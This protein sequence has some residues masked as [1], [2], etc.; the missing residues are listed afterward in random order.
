MGSPAIAGEPIPARRR[1]TTGP[2]RKRSELEKAKSRFG[3]W[4][5]VPSTV[6]LVVLL[7]VPTLLTLDYSFRENTSGGSGVGAYVGFKNFRTVLDTPLFWESLR[8]TVIFAAGFVLISTVVGLA[9]A[10]LLNQRFRGRGL[11]RALLILPWACPWLV[12]GILWNRFIGGTTNGGLAQILGWLHIMDPNTS[13][14]AHPQWALVMTIIA[15][16]WRQACFAAILFLAGLQ[17]L[18]DELNEA[19]SMDGAGIWRRFRSITLPWLRPVLISVTVLNVIYGFL[20]FD[21]IY[22]LTHGGPGTATETLSILIYQTLFLHTHI[23]TGSAVSVIL[24]LLS[25]L[26]G[27]LAVRLLDRRSEVA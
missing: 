14:L 21:I 19:A 27:V 2:G 17:S 15:S 26:G 6:V 18:P 4:L 1:P 23:G 11:A 12:I 9:A 25:L 7:F 8:I 20:Q 22:S 13:I 16:A 24:G 10:M 3:R 5:V